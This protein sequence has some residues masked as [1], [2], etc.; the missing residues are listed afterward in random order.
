MVSIT[1]FK[2]RTNYLFGSVH[3]TGTL[4][5]FNRMFFISIMFQFVHLCAEKTG[6]TE[7]NSTCYKK[8]PR[9]DLFNEARD[10]SDPV[11][12]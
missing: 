9:D 6:C 1:K 10:P 5:L 4:V 7:K 2:V 8:L 3:R 12:R 11:G